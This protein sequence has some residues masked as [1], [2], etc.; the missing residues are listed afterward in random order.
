MQQMRKTKI[1]CTIGPASESSDMLRRLIHAGMN[2]ARFNFS[3]GDHAEHKAKYDRLVSLRREMNLPVATLLDTRGPEIRLGKFGGGKAV[4]EKGQKFVL[5]T[6]EVTGDKTRASVTHRDLPADVRVGGAILID[7]GLIEMTVDEVRGKEI[8]CTVLNGGPVSD[9]KGVNVPGA[10]LSMPFI[11]E[12]DRADILFGCE[13]GF[14]I[15]AC[16]FT[17]TAEDIREVKRLLASRGGHMMIIAKI[18]SVQGVENLEE[19]LQEADGIMVARGDLGV[20]VPLQ[21]V[22]SLQKQM[23]KLAE[24]EGKQVITATQMLDSMI[25]NPRPT[26][27]E[28]TDVA[29]AIY[30][31]TTAIMLSG[32]T[33]NGEYPVQAVETMASIAERTEVDIDYLRRMSRRMVDGKKVDV[34]TAIS[35]SACT[36]AADIHADA[37]ITVTMSGF[38][39]TRLSRYKPT[40][41]ILA[42]TTKSSVACRLNILFD[43]YPLIIQEE[44]NMEELFQ[45]AIR[46]ARLAG[47]VKPGDTVVL[48]AG[49]PLG[50][51]GKTN[52]VR[53]EDVV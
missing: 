44:D 20:E 43:T 28:V 50:S 14:D 10:K 48:T 23:I 41:P 17:R 38:T 37:V 26:R 47:Y 21:N 6:E 11:S 12:R 34:T 29:N 27:A 13:L 35:H 18:E 30:D 39:A 49:V 5:T 19:I 51:S 25:H 16:S 33:A 24:R 3:H 46:Q 40:C 45:S 9:H 31:G 2:V 42:C 8:F 7:D 53:V 15:I 22:P 32:E 1:V 52:M 4:L 36:I